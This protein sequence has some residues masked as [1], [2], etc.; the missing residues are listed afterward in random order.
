MY[1]LPQAAPISDMRNHQPEI[2]DMAKSGPVMLTSRGRAAAVLL[3]PEKWNE[4]ALRL[5]NLELL[6]EAKR[7]EAEIAQDPTRLVTDE[8]LERQLTAKVARDV[9]N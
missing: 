1:P 3:S 4:I 6:L 8:E 2:L 7:I 9:A 5:R